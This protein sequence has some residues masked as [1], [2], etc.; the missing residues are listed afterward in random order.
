M[1][2]LLSLGAL[3]KGG[4]MQIAPSTW[5]NAEHGGMMMEAFTPFA[6]NNKGPINLLR[7]I[8]TSNNFDTTY[9]PICWRK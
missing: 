4:R 8:Y 2:L 7:T 3:A 1:A 6:C 5:E 9:L